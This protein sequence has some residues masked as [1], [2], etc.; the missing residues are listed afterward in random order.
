MGILNVLL[1]T[2]PLNLVE[3][4]PAVKN[5]SLLSV[6]SSLVRYTLQ[7]HTHPVDSIYLSE[8]GK[9]CLSNDSTHMDRSLRMW[10]LQHGNTLLDCVSFLPSPHRG[11]RDYH[12]QK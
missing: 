3:S 12:F 5:L 7:G 8:D 2:A 11:H 6:V 1:Y 4:F 10:D 9:R